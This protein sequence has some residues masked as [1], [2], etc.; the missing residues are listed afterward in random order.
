MYKPWTENER[1]SHK[2]V[3]LKYNVK[4]EIGF[5]GVWQDSMGA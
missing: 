4:A 3:T 2:S 1:A 5:G